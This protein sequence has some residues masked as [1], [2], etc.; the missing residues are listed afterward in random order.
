M[1]PTVIPEM[2]RIFLRFIIRIFRFILKFK[3]YSTS[4]FCYMAKR[5]AKY[6]GT[7]NDFILL[8]GSEELEMPEE[9]IIHHACTRHTGIGAD[10]LIVLWAS[11]EADFRVDYYNSDGKLGS[12]CGNG[13]RCAVHF[14]HSHALFSGNSCSFTAADGIHHAVVDE[15][16]WVRVEFLDVESGTLENGGCF[17]N[18]GSPHLVLETDDI[19][20]IPVQQLGA[21]L[22]YGAYEPR[23]GSNINWVERKENTFSM[24]TYERGVEA[25]TLS[26]GTGAVAVALYLHSR[27]G[28]SSPVRLQ[29]RGGVLEVFFVALDSG[30]TDIAL[31]GPA[32]PVYEGIWPW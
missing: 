22:R 14:A 2:M 9:A 4:Y 5:F 1:L 12:L 8:M 10:G 13:S 32:T 25:E 17:Y 11:D 19:E 24:R 6:H 16:G 15:K 3:N 7:G 26:C 18:T 21:A 28:I 31:K 20:Q 27:Y 23:G 29:A 30:Y